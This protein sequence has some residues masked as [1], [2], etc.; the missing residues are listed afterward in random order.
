MGD[1]CRSNGGLAGHSPRLLHL[2]A[3]ET[4][5]EGVEGEGGEGGEGGGC[6]E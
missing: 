4:G 1:I 2:Y 6:E 5:G 3:G